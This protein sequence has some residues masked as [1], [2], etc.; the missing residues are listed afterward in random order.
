MVHSTSDYARRKGRAVAERL[1]QTE[2]LSFTS[3]VEQYMKIATTAISLWIAPEHG[4]CRLESCDQ[5][6]LNR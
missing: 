4:R 2:Q 1:H 3:D 6:R 5:R